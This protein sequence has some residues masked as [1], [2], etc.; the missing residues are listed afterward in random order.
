MSVPVACL[1]LLRADTLH[2]GNDGSMAG[3]DHHDRRGILH[4]I[5]LKPIRILWFSRRTRI[6][7]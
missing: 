2:G 7:M 1:P 3:H 5:Q 6:R 4:I